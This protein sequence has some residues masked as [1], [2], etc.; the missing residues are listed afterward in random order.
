MAS[1]SGDGS[2]LVSVVIPTYN[3]PALL[4]ET[5]ETVAAQ[6]F[7][8]YEI[9]IIDDGS[10]DETL[11][12]LQPL[13]DSASGRIIVVSQENRGIGAAR[14]RGISK[15]RGKYVALL[16]HDDLWMPGKL[17]AQVAYLDSHP[18]CIACSVPWSISTNA[19]HCMFSLSACDSNGI[20]H[21][22][23]ALFATGENPLIT[24][25]LMFRRES[26]VGLQY[27]T[28]RSCIEDVPF[29]LGL[30]SR[31]QLGIAGTE[32][33]MI[34]RE[35]SGG[36]SRQAAF[37]HN[38]VIMLRRLTR[39]GRFKELMVRRRQSLL[40]YLAYLGRQAIYH[41][42]TAGKRTAAASLYLREIPHQLRLGRVRF[43]AIVPLL[44]ALPTNLVRRRWNHY[45]TR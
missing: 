28:E 34:Y 12:R 2:P 45:S 41:D 42:I 16:D 27:E 6:D 4:L 32:T 19:Q 3:A 30:F 43:L 40:A 21:D 36:A 44:I 5:L 37:F 24:S 18:E 26:A 20:I 13:V 25:S 33:A 23:M 39:Q 35:H 17:G 8:D 9:I 7:A 22:P 31:G 10:T 1:C 15:A 38:G 11:S 14:N 29:Q